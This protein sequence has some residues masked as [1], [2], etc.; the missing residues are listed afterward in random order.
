MNHAELIQQWN[1]LR[2]QVIIAQLAPSALLI[3]SVALLQFG[4]A[5]ARLWV[6]LAFAG[7][8]LASG[9]LGAL[10]EYAAATE[11]ISVAEDLRQSPEHS[12]QSK[13]II[14]FSPWMNVVRFVTPAIFVAIFGAIMFALFFS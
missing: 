5:D 2:D 4:L 10:A 12:F 14:A 3:T 6:K 1:K 7:I 11:A 13:Q 8:L 9:I